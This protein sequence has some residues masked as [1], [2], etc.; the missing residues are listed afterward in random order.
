MSDVVYS[1]QGLRRQS[2]SNSVNG[3]LYISTQIPT[4]LSPSL[5]YRM[6]VRKNV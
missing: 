1:R 3:R 6:W 4:S 5:V 2:L